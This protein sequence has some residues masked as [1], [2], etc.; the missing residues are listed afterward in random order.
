MANYKANEVQGWA[1]DDPNRDTRISD[2]F[3]RAMRAMTRYISKYHGNMCNEFQKMDKD[4]N[5]ALDSFELREGFARL[6]VNVSEEIWRVII[7]V[8]DED[9]SGMVE[10]PELMDTISRW[11]K[12]GWKAVEGKH[13]AGSV[14]DSALA[15]NEMYDSVAHHTSWDQKDFQVPF[16]AVFRASA[17]SHSLTVTIAPTLTPTCTHHTTGY[18]RQLRAPKAASVHAEE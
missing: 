13:G 1:A 5:G 12:G 16:P 17:V 18:P 3:S 9:A 15:R 10:L 14:K 7:D 2:E 6:G 4:Q 8:I 11:A